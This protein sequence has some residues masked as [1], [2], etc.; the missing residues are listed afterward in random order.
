MSNALPEPTLYR[1]VRLF[2]QHGVEY[3]IAGGQAEILHGSARLTY[4]WDFCY[5]RSVD[6][7]ERLA[8]ALKETHPR[9]RNA[10][11]DL[12]FTLDGKSLALAENLTLDTDLGP[13]DLLGY[14]EPVGV[15]EDIEERAEVYELGEY[16]VKAVSLDDLIRIKE[17]LGRPKD[18]ESL[19]HLR[20]IRQVREERGEA[21]RFRSAGTCPV[22]SPV[23]PFSA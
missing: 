16:R 4:A 11:P 12:P 18:R 6:S 3:L 23:A 14:M 13:L 10:P 2:E 5:R 1:F 7:L 15:Y 20:A 22:R 21:W 8:T 19:L 17:H 9:L